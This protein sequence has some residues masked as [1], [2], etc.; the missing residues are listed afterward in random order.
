M[1]SGTIVIVRGTLAFLMGFLKPISMSVHQHAT[2][3]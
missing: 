3:Q 1:K 2:H